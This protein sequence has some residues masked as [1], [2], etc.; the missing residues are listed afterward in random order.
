MAKLVSQDVYVGVP[1]S[2]EDYKNDNLKLRQYNEILEGQV[3][4]FNE[5]S[6]LVD[7]AEKRGM[8]KELVRFKQDCRKKAMEMAAQS[9]TADV[10]QNIQANIISA[11]DKYYQWLTKE[12]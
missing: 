6:A 4:A 2:L 1:P 10:A 11:A 3:K 7:A 12:V 5:Q 9:P 8:N